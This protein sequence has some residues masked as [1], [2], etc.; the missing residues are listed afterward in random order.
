MII[1]LLASL[2]FILTNLCSRETKAKTSNTWQL[3]NP[4]K[5]RK[6]SN[7]F[8]DCL[9]SLE[10]LLFK[11]ASLLS[12]AFQGV[13]VREKSKCHNFCLTKKEIL[14]AWVTRINLL[15][16]FVKDTLLKPMTGL[17]TLLKEQTGIYFTNKPSI[18]L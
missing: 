3:L 10:T 13:I 4:R 15:H 14:G 2:I 17:N 16:F 12:L 8:K 1:Y 9:L 7:I 6:K 18:Y 11:I 5:R